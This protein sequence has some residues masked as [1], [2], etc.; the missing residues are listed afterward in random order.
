MIFGCIVLA[1]FILMAIAGH[2]IEENENKEKERRKNY[3]YRTT[4][5]EE[6]AVELNWP[7]S[8]KIEEKEPYRPLS[9]TYMKPKKKIETPLDSL[10]V[11]LDDVMCDKQ[12]DIFSSHVY[13]SCS[14]HD[15]NT[16]CSH[17][18]HNDQS[19]SHHDNSYSSH[20]DSSSSHHDSDCS[21][22]HSD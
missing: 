21:S 18:H 3:P 4:P 6:P 22:H 13:P 1:V 20:C 14:H 7:Q 17:H 12:N 11:S 15:N 16:D 9:T 2:V 5:P 19:C 10:S 8:T